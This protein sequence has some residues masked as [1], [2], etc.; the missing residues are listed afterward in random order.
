MGVGRIRGGVWLGVVLV[1]F[2]GWG[3]CVEVVAVWGS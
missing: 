2:G 1:G 3:G